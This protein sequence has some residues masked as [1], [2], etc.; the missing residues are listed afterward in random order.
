MSLALEIY[1]VLFQWVKSRTGGSLVALFDASTYSWTDKLINEYVVISVRNSLGARRGGAS[2]SCT[3]RRVPNSLIIRSLKFNSITHT[4]FVTK[5]TRFLRYKAR[6]PNVVLEKSVIIWMIMFTY[7][8]SCL[9]VSILVTTIIQKTVYLR[10]R[11]SLHNVVSFKSECISLRY[12][13]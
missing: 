10:P 5:N 8:N 9:W 7:R 12:Y 4:N 1:K 6:N 2:W 13:V 3:D 11:S